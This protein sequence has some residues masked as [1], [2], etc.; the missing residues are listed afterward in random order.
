MCP[1]RTDWFAFQVG[2]GEIIHAR[3]T[4]VATSIDI[5][6]RLQTVMAA[7]DGTSTA[8]ATSVTTTGIEEINWT[9]TSAGMYYLK[10]Y[11][12]QGDNQPYTL[13]IY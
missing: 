11:T 3:A 4:F 5:D 10:I 9:A 12:Y 8:V 1:C 6:M 2:A 7:E 13:R